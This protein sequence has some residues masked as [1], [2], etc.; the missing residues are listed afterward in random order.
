[1]GLNDFFGTGDKKADELGANL[2]LESVVDTSTG[3]LCFI[4]DFLCIP[5][6]LKETPFSSDIFVPNAAFGENVLE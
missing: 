1:M 6:N 3:V 2:F 4:M 5:L